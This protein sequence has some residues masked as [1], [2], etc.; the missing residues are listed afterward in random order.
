MR[1]PAAPNRSTGV[2][3]LSEDDRR[4]QRRIWLAGTAA[5]LALAAACAGWVALRIPRDIADRTLAALQAAGLDPRAELSVD[6][7]TV[8]LSGEVPDAYT[9][10]RMRAI[11]GAVR[12]VRAVRDQLAVAP[13][14]TEPAPSPQ[15]APPPP[16]AAPKRVHPSGP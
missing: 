15:T 5:L 3:M 2:S 10:A 11:A 12:G 7:R 6:G 8:T 16:T 13:L 14:Q 4:T 1:G 9:R